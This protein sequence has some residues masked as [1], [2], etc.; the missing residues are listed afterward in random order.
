M[1]TVWPCQ[2]NRVAGGAV[3]ADTCHTWALYSCRR[4]R[5]WTITSQVSSAKAC[6]SSSRWTPTG[7]PWTVKSST[8]FSDKVCGPRVQKLICIGHDV[9]VSSV[10]AIT[11]ANSFSTG[12]SGIEGA[13]H[14]EAANISGSCK[15]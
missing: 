11:V 12:V 4:T 10:C 1:I 13:C 3:E 6:V 2:M 9:P 14:W 5:E 8:S 15:Q 7:I